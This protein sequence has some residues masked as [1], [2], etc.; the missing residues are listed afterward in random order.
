MEMP[1]TLKLWT[2]ALTV[3]F[4]ASGNRSLM[5]T[6]LSGAVRVNSQKLV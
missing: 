3:M 6:A 1:G 4:G 2:S 5:V